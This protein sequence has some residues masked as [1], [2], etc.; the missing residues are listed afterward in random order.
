MKKRKTTIITLIIVIIAIV[1]FFTFSRENKQVIKLES[2]AVTKGNIF[3]TVTATGTVAP[4]D[5]VDVGTQ[6]SG[7]IKKIYVDFN[8]T[9]KKGQLLAELDR[10][11]LNAIMVQSQA[12]LASAQNELTY[13][14]Q[15]YT[16]SKKLFETSMVSEVDYQLAQYN[17]NNAKT[18]VERLKS[19][20]EQAKVNLSY[21]T[22]Y[23]P[24]D[25]IILARNVDEG[26]TVAASFS[27]PTLFSIAK[28]LT[29]MKVQANVD[30]ADIG[31]VKLDQ[32]VTF[33][34][35]AYPDDNFEGKVT[36][37]RLNPTVSANVVTYQ[38]IIEAPN[39]DLKLMPGLT[40][41]VSIITKN[42]DSVVLV[43][44]KALRFTPDAD[45]SS[46]YIVKAF[47]RDSTMHKRNMSSGTYQGAGQRVSQG[48]SQNT[49]SQ[50]GGL[51][52]SGNTNNRTKKMK[53]NFGS[54][55]TLSG[56]TLIQ[57]MVRTGLENGTMVEIQKGL[58][59]G[60][61]II[62]ASTKVQKNAKTTEAKSPF[63]PQMPKRG[64]R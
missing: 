8:S 23:S 35:D 46:K 51:S 11:T 64:G 26:Q 15:N 18:N 24:I 31:Q 17:Y 37:I 49:R 25:G 33:T 9:V 47:Q 40:A 57:K 10:S 44:A 41:S 36:Q 48:N 62:V 42:A 2:A 6:V 39:P 60:D 20:L 56:D 14:E 19:S 3:N 30:E 22:I 58:K 61:S 59:E 32:K 29:K 50:E 52:Q 63:M 54:V 27:T 53:K 28:D 12:S 21:A 55:W 16:R 34:V 45:V 4:I 1:A 13:Q 5:K 38:V 43:P 7:V